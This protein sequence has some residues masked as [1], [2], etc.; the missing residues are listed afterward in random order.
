[1]I[2]TASSGNRFVQ[3]ERSLENVR[4][5]SSYAEKL[6]KHFIS[7]TASCKSVPSNSYSAGI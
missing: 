3:A 1:M 5:G 7:L 2:Q 4:G 6:V